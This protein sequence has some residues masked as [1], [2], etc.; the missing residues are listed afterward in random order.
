[1]QTHSLTLG[2]LIGAATVRSCEIIKTAEK[3]EFSTAGGLIRSPTTRSHGPSNDFVSPHAI[4]FSN[5]GISSHDLRE[6]YS[7]G[8]LL[9]AVTVLGRSEEHTSE[10][11]SL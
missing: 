5:S 4:V 1:M 9:Y 3:R 7:K 10:L 11:Q 2:A 6:R 8:E